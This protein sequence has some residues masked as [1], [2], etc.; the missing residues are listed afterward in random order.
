MNREMYS[1]AEI[2]CVGTNLLV[3]NS[4]LSLTK[5]ADVD[6]GDRWSERLVRK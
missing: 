3:C 2:W 4:A 5:K 1:P 6:G